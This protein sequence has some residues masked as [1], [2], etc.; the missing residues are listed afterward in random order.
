MIHSQPYLDE[1]SDTNH[2]A[3]YE[4]IGGLVII[5]LG[6]NLLSN[7]I[8]DRGREA[9][10]HSD[11]SKQRLKDIDFLQKYEGKTEQQ[12]I[13]EVDTE[14]KKVDKEYDEK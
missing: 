6:L 9:L 5:T 14:D 12:A 13:E 11:K 2:K 4:T 3:W 1:Q 10:R 8:Y 7:F